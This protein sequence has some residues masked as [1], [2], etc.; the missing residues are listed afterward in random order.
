MITRIF[1]REQKSNWTSTL[2]GKVF[3]LTSRQS[4]TKFF[5]C[6]PNV[7][8]NLDQPLDAEV[9]ISRKETLKHI[10]DDRE[11]LTQCAIVRIMKR[12]KRLFHKEL[13]LKVMDELNKR[14]RPETEMIIR[15]LQLSIGKDFIAH[16]KND[17]DYY[18]YVD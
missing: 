5:L 11:V 16:D 15:S 10:D 12:D 14:F 6:R 4:F 18:V 7:R 8:I 9:E 3:K 2:D 13:K 1:N 17:K